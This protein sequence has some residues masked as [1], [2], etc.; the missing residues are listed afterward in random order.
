MDGPTP[1]KTAQC[2]PKELRK[3]SGLNEKYL[4][5]VLGELEEGDMLAWRPTGQIGYTIA[6]RGRTRYSHVGVFCRCYGLPMVAEV[7]EFL[8]GRVVSLPTQI[9]E[10]VGDIDVY[11][12]DTKKFPEFNREGAVRYMLQY[13]G[14][15]YGYFGVL[16]LALLH[17]PY[18]CRLI[19][20]NANDEYVDDLPVFCSQAISAADRIGGG[21]DPVLHVAD[22][23]TEPGDLPASHLYE[24]FCTLI[25]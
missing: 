13:A 23:S 19:T 22:N 10:A 16:K 24:Y 20:R 11:K 18:L 14:Q 1:E 21:V 25:G 8:G 15:G 3:V 9:R 5:E 7:R 6:A 2:I 12:V 17:T 4:D